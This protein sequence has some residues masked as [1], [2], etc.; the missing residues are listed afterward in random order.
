ML[1]LLFFDTKPNFKF[2]SGFCFEFR[3]KLL[4]F[5]SM[6]NLAELHNNS[7]LYRKPVHGRA[8]AQLAEAPTH[9]SPW[10]WSLLD[11]YTEEESAILQLV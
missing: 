6:P 1:G 11:S 2:V 8:L 7:S 5:K 3:S 10:W 4:D 9:V